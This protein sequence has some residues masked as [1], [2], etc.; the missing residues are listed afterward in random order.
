MESSAVCT[1]VPD[2][3]AG[4]MA[5]GELTFARRLLVASQHVAAAN[6]RGMDATHNVVIPFDEIEAHLHPRWQRS[7]VKGLRTAIPRVC[8]A[9]GLRKEELQLFLSTHSPLV[10]ASL[11]DEFASADAKNDKWFDFDMNMS[12]HKV[13]ISETTFVPQGSRHDR[14]EIIS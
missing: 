2:R 10:M 9:S 3:N 12:T 7:V 8:E 11:E 13:D 5:P 14:G 6:N 4:P 1:H